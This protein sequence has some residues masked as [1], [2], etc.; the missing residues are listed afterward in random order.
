M[1]QRIVPGAPPPAPLSKTQKKRRK[2]K[3]ADNSDSVDIPDTTSAALVEKAPEPSDIQQGSV[4]QE[5]VAEPEPELTAEDISLKPSPIAELINKRLKATTKKIASNF[6]SSQLNLTIFQG[7]IAAYAATDPSKLNDDQ[8]AT[9]KSLPT[10]EAIQKE[11]AEVKKTIEVLYTRLSYSSLIRI[12][13]YEAELALEL[14]AQKVE[15]MKAEK[16]RIAAAVSDAQVGF[17]PSF[18]AG[19]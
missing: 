6:T 13:S 1:Q 10:L 12:Q 17:L 18:P 19:Y 7:R 5:L 8:K 15:A 14:A 3:K 4:A 2:A 9:L 16:T 11:L